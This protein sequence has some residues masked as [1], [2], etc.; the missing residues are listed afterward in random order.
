M[1]PRF[2]NLSTARRFA[3]SSAALSAQ[4][5]PWMS[6]SIPTL[7]PIL[8]SLRLQRLPSF[9]APFRLANAGSFGVSEITVYRQPPLFI[10]VIAESI[11]VLQRLFDNDLS[12]PITKIRSLL[13]TTTAGAA[14]TSKP[15]PQQR[16]IPP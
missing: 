14:A 10:Q 16:R 11:E 1:S 6:D 9:K 8:F 15:A 2:I 3:S 4:I 13:R 12:L 5:F 7:I